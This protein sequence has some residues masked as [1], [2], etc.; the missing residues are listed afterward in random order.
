MK[1][2]TNRRLTPEEEEILSAKPDLSEE[3]SEKGDKGFPIKKEFKNLSRI[4]L[5]EE[6]IDMVLD[7][8]K[9]TDKAGQK[10]LD[11]IIRRVVLLLKSGKR[12]TFKPFK[13]GD[14]ET[15]PSGYKFKDNTKIQGVSEKDLPVEFE[16]IKLA[17][18]KFGSIKINTSCVPLIVK[19]TYKD[20]SSEETEF[21]TLT[22][23]DLK[24]FEIILPKKAK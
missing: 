21:L 9:I 6:L 7:G 20:G 18:K 17:L 13:Y 4:I 10:V 19:N 3:E 24:G 11:V 15:T 1:E 8:N 22:Y 5:E 12:L 14:M 23:A 16:E 2:E